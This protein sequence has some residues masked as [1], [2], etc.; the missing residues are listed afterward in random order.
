MKNK[1]GRLYDRAEIYDLIENEQ[2]TENIR[3]DWEQFLTERQ[4]G[5]FLDVSI[6]TGDMTLP[7]QELGIDIYGSDLSEEMLSR[8]RK[9]S[10]AKQKPV[11]LECCDFRDLSCWKDMKF[12]CVASTGNVLEYVSNED[13]LKTIEKI[14]EHIKPGGYFCFDSRN[15]EIDK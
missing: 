9:K 8:C 3:N 2:R 6:E 14:Y 10:V 7:S 4:I 15:W 5:T 12:D 11:R 13:V 1:K